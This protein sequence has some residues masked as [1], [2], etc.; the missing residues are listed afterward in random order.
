MKKL[1]FIFK[2]SMKF[3]ETL[4]FSCFERKNESSLSFLPSQLHKQ[5]ILLL[6]HLPVL[7]SQNNQQYANT[8]K[9]YLDLYI[10]NFYYG[11]LSVCHNVSH[12]SILSS[13]SQDFSSSPVFLFDWDS[14]KTMNNL[15][16]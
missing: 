3:I 6:S 4:M 12:D 13:F 5:V 14:L 9:H 15:N 7:S 11:F 1:P 10:N 2:D 16:S 8:V